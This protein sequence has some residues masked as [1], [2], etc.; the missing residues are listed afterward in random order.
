[1]K[2]YV[3]GDRSGLQRT[4]FANKFCQSALTP[5]AVIG[6]YDGE[7]RSFRKIWVG[8]D[9]HCA[10]EL[11]ADLIRATT[12][13]LAIHTSVCPAHKNRVS[14]TGKPK[15]V[16]PDTFILK[17]RNFLIGLCE[18]VGAIYPVMSFESGPDLDPATGR[19]LLQIGLAYVTQ[20]LQEETAVQSHWAEDLLDATLRALS[21][22]FIAVTEHCMIHYDGR[23]G[24]DVSPDS[25]DWIVSNGRLT[26]C[27]VPRRQDL[28]EAVRDATGTARC[29]S[30]IPVFAGSGAA[31]LVV[32]TPIAGSD[33]PLALILSE[34]RA[35]D[36]FNLREQFFNAYGL[37]RS[38][39]LTAH[40]ILGGKSMAEAAVAT[41]LSVATVRSYMKQIFCKTG[42]HRQ[43]E[44][45][46]LYFMSILPVASNSEL[47]A[48]LGDGP[49][50][51]KLRFRPT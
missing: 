13:R 48:M 45:I 17:E 32:V 36:H 3:D 40:A 10:P 2:K 15:D 43:T 29:T 44:L 1:M 28:E 31:K 38:E 19:A 20:Q 37:T 8:S 39:R 25:P 49:N 22:E 12:T 18:P 26:L 46:S 24:D 11:C 50:V 33:P 9:G 47:V 27:D 14:A 51:P 23:F 41:N 34:G 16:Q 4:E 5:A 7:K 6:F 35:V 42:V 30:I 21:I